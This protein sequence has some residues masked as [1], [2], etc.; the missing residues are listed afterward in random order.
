MDIKEE[1]V[2]LALVKVWRVYEER[3]DLAVS[4]KNTRRGINAREFVSLRLSSCPCNK[5][6]QNQQR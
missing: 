6:H 1:W 4:V 2:G 3:L 5:T